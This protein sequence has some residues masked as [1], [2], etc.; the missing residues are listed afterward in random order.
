MSTRPKGE[1]SPHGDFRSRHRD[2][3][4]DENDRRQSRT[5]W[6]GGEPVQELGI[7]IGVKV[8]QFDLRCAMRFKMRG[9]KMKHA[10][11]MPLGS[12]V[13]VN[14]HG[15]RLHEAKQQRPVRQDGKKISHWNAHISAA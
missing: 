1:R 9:V 8:P 10:A 12:L 5:G 7:I 3:G 11:R 2:N 14:V 13:L 15:W 4:P 6:G